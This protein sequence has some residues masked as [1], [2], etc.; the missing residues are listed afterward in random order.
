[1]TVNKLSQS[2]ESLLFRK[3]R[4]LERQMLAFKAP[5]PTAAETLAVTTQDTGNPGATISALAAGS[6]S[7]VGFLALTG[8]P[9]PDRDFVNLWGI[10][11][12][13]RVDVNDEDHKWPNGISLTAGQKKLNVVARSDYD[14]VV[15]DSLE[16]TVGTGYVTI[17]NEDSASHTY[18]VRV[19]YSYV[20]PQ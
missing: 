10:H 3:I 2:A 19:R 18:Y 6:G 9:G 5:Q 16:E 7:E 13:V 17:V 15:L 4:D 11:F 1:M 12:S 14:S 20:D 8:T